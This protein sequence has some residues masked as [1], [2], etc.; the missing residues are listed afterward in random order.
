MVRENARYADPSDEF[1]AKKWSF[2]VQLISGPVWF[3]V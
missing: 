1:R 2:E 3:L